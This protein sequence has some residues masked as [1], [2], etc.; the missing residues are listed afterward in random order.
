MMRTR[1]LFGVGLACLLASVCSTAPNVDQVPVGQQVQITT[2]DGGVV[3]GKLTNKDPQAVIVETARSTRQIP[4]AS[5]ADVEVMDGKTPV[6]LPPMAKFREYTVPEG[7]PIAVRLNAPVSSAT[8]HAGDPVEGVLAEPVVVDG[9]NVLPSGSFV[10]GEVTEAQPSGKVKGLAN[11]ALVFKT[12]TANG[13]DERYDISA[14]WRREAAATKAEDAKKIGIG[15]GAGAIVGALVGGGKGAGI[16]AAIGGGA[17]TGVVLS[18]SGK[19]VT[20][21]RGA[22][23]NVS[24]TKSVDVRVPIEPDR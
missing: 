18:T 13:R 11:L 23:L 8:N 5:I 21:E 1:T 2:S 12:I 14:R 9:V 7:T 22:V 10:A 15:A 17:G 24:L 19:E 6:K 4:R 3:T 20:L 16:G